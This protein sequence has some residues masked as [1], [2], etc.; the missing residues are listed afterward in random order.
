[1]RIVSAQWRPVVGFDMYEVSNLGEV[2][3]L[4]HGTARILK[5]HPAGKGYL[6]VM[7]Y[8]P[9]GRRAFYVHRLVAAAFL[10]DS[11]GREVNH[12]NLMKTDNAATNLE[13]ATRKQ[14]MAHAKDHGRYEVQHAGGQTLAM[15]NAKRAKKLSPEQ[16]Q[17]IR[18][19][20]ADGAMRQKDI[21]EMFGVGQAVVSAIHR[22]EAWRAQWT[23]SA[24]RSA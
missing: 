1:M 16:A 7:L 14:N 20:A 24:R 9:Q 2:R 6:F 13:W 22:G 15:N 23:G 18:R 21:G 11:E 8:G 19:L 12:K 3:S 17:E 4:R 5:Q 10:G